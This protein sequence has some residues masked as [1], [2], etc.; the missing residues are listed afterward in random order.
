MGKYNYILTHS[1]N[2]KD[3]DND[4]DSISQGNVA[5]SRSGCEPVPVICERISL[6][7]CSLKC[8]MRDADRVG[9]DVFPTLQGT[10]IRVFSACDTRRELEIQSEFPIWYEKICVHCI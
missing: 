3:K 1:R 4:E 8:F 2:C 9:T 7:S 6:L 10:G 5:E